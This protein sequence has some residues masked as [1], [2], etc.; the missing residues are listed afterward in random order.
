LGDGA[1]ERA[2]GRQLIYVGLEYTRWGLT[3]RRLRRQGLAVSAGEAEGHRNPVAQTSMDRSAAYFP[4]CGD[5]AL[6]VEG[7]MTSVEFVGAVEHKSSAGKH[8]LA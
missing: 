1:L 8:A 3:D 7:E 6:E 4:H 2:P 5:Q